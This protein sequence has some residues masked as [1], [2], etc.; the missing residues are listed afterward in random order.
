MRIASFF[1]QVGTA[2]M[3]MAI[4]LA[5]GAAV[6]PQDIAPA[7]EVTV[8][9]TADGKLKAGLWEVRLSRSYLFGRVRRA[10]DIL[11]TGRDRVFRFCLPDTKIADVTRSLAGEGAI[12]GSG[13]LTC[14]KLIVQMSNGSLTGRQYCNG[15]T[16][17]A[18]EPADPQFTPESTTSAAMMARP[19]GSPIPAREEMT[20]KGNYS[21]DQ[22]FLEFIDEIK[23][24]EP[25]QICRPGGLCTE[26]SSGRRW[27]I[28][29]ARVSDCPPPEAEASNTP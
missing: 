24:I 20:I 17:A 19:E 7:P 25:T 16:L 26:D 23:P 21:A 13:S 27:T 2:G 29:G 1:E 15:A 10:Q 18:R 4:W 22:V 12:M 5:T 3:A 8:V 28:K 14:S 6:P 11:A 9:G